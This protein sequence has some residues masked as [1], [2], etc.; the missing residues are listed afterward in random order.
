VDGS[1]ALPQKDLRT[2]GRRTAMG[3]VTTIGLY[4]AKNVFRYMALMPR[5]WQ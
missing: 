3:S 1:P 4:P 5:E 2:A